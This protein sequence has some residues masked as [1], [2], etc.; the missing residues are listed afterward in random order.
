MEFLE[1]VGNGAVW[2]VGFALALGATRSAGGLLRGAAKTTIRTG[3]TLGDWVRA[4]TEEGRETLQDLY[5]EARAE[6]E[7]QAEHGQRA[8]A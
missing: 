5:H 6:R 7:G 4:S 2:G 1:A 8:S 3:L